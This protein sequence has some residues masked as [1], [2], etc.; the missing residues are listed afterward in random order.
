MYSQTPECHDEIL[1]K[2]SAAVTTGRARF[3]RPGACTPEASRLIVSR[4]IGHPMFDFLITTLH[5]IELC[6]NYDS[7]FAVT[8]DHSSADTG[9]HRF[10][11][12][13]MGLIAPGAIVRQPHREPRAVA[14]PGLHQDQPLPSLAATICRM[15]SRQPANYDPQAAQAITIRNPMRGSSR[16]PIRGERGCHPDT[17]AGASANCSLYGNRIDENVGRTSK[18]PDYFGHIHLYAR[19]PAAAHGRVLRLWLR[20]I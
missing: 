7:R 19:L 9:V 13:P 4:S 16:I 12:R 8:P 2:P 18:T 3:A 5:S 1:A 14:R 20:R 15:V 6:S 10:F 11:R 17:D